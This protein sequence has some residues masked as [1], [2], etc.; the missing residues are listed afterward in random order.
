VEL[1]FL[2][3]SGLELLTELLE[4]AVEPVLFDADLVQIAVKLLR[5]DASGVKFFLALGSDIAKPALSRQL[6]LQPADLLSERLGLSAEGITLM[7]KGLNLFGGT[8]AI[9]IP[10][11]CEFSVESLVVLPSLVQFLFEPVLFT[12]SLIDLRQ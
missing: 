10:E 1:F 7:Q 4:L 3:V 9:A 12:A 2:G 5:F 6:G 8:I 11:R